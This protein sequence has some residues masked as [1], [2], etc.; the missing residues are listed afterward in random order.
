[1]VGLLLG[2]GIFTWK[3]KGILP[4]VKDQE[5]SNCCW[6]IATLSAIEAHHK[7]ATNHEIKLSTQELIDFCPRQEN[8]K[9]HPRKAL[10]YII[11]SGVSYADE[12]PFVGL[13]DVPTHKPN[14]TRKYNTSDHYGCVSSIKEMKRVIKDVGPIVASVRGKPFGD[15]QGSDIYGLGLDESN[16]T[17]E[18]EF[19]AVLL[20]GY[21][22]DK[23]NDQYYWIV[24]NSWGKNWGENGYGRVTQNAYIV[25]P[26]GWYPVLNV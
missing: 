3:D 19:H 4:D 10:E 17:G 14:W 20:I 18:K 11:E 2:R 22:Y 21:G 9:G 5:H 23:E 25:K 15:V 16:I 12:Y 8:G 1:M 6:A 26:R 13:R 24:Q 7:K